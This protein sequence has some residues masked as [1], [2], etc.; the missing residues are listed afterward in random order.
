MA[1]IKNRNYW[2]PGGY[3]V[4]VPGAGMDKPFSGSFRECVDWVLRFRRANPAMCQRE[5]WSLEPAQVESYVDAYNTE[6][7][8]RGGYGQFVALDQDAPVSSSPK[9]RPGHGAGPAAAAKAA[10]AAYKDMFANGPV[11]HEQAEAR[12]AV[13]VA[14]PLN[15][16]K[17]GLVERFTQE[18]A[19][20]LTSLVSI[21]RDSNLTTSRDSRLG[22]CD[23][24]DCPMSAKVHARLESFMGKMSPDQ[25]KA[26]HPTCWIR[27]EAAAPAAG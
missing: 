21:M 10:F 23:A 5:G 6:R 18:V 8:L 3:Q 24:C 12:A 27:S 1:H 22:V 7:M 14:C 4:L 11:P 2:I 13:C 26:L 25:W 17:G 16:T 15:N 9:A 20:Q 19:A